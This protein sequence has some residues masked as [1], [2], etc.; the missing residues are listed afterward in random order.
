MILAI[1]RPRPVSKNYGIGR[2]RR[3]LGL[4]LARWVSKGTEFDFLKFKWYLNFFHWISDFT[5]VSSCKNHLEV[6]ED[7]MIS[8]MVKRTNSLI[9]FCR[10]TKSFCKRC[11]GLF[12]QR[13]VKWTNWI[14][15]SKIQVIWTILIEFQFWLSLL[16]LTRRLKVIDDF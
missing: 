5:M 2:R 13:W 11:L 8:L 4:F 12:K 16:K 10:R 7:V 1:W 9:A 3:P 6:V 15:I 14:R